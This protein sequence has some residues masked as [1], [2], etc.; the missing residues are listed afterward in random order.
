VNERLILG[1]RLVKG[2][3]V[4]ARVRLA[5]RSSLLVVG[6]TQ[7][8][9]TSSLVVPAIL[10]WSGAVVVTSVKSDVVTVT[11]RWRGAL[12]EV[13]VLEPGRDRGLT[14]DPLEGVDSMRLAMR[15]AHELTSRAGAHADSDFWNALAAKFVAALFVR[16]RERGLDVFD[17]AAVVESRDFDAWL[18]RGEA[19][20]LLS[21]F[22]RHDAKTLDGV[23]T[24]AE[25]MLLPWRFA[26]P[27]ASVRR[28][29]H[30]TNTLY[31]VS[32][33]GEQRHYEALFRGA[34]RVVLEEQQRLS[35][36][37]RARAL[38]LVLDEAA[39]V[40]PLEDLD[41]LAA[42]LA[43]FSVT[44]VTVVQDFAQLSA[45]WGQRAATIVNNHTTRCVLGGLADPGVAT[46]LPEA[47]GPAE[48]PLRQ[49]PPGTAVVVARSA[50]AI[51]VRLR[52]WWTQA[53]LR[54]R[55][56]VDLATIRRWQRRAR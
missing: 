38:L 15:V 6:P 52:P 35:D 13:Q 24:T 4:G 45:R 26:Q 39:S 18:G 22:L 46:Y 28:V 44:L 34:L 31:L 9:K 37:G 11:R 2:V 41:E 40:A 55:G 33:R 53:H 21:D 7:V 42:T 25:T 3:G 54:P 8:G 19:A 51:A 36:E 20:T 23:L 17:V 30:G 10:G 50:P 56:H 27:L 14:W 12:G 1:R 32:P 48:R 43:G 49:R 16:A 5:E 47:A 29:V